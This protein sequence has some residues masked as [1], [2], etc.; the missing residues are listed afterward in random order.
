M[1]ISMTTVYLLFNLLHPRLPQLL[2]VY[3]RP[4]CWLAWFIAGIFVAT[5]DLAVGLGP[6]GFQASL[7][8]WVGYGGGSIIGIVLF[9][10]IIKWIRTDGKATN[11]NQNAEVPFEQL[12]QDWPRLKSWLLREEPTDDDFLKN[13]PI[14]RRLAKYLANRGGTVGLVGPFGSGK[15]SVVKWLEQELDA[16]GSQSQT[17]VWHCQVS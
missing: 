5:V 14:A 1:L 3:K 2:L 11:N 7:L 10:S 16:K 17:E 6:T 4:P 9:Q 8:E 13:R 15:T 12:I